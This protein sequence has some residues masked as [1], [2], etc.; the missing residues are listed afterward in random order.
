MITSTTTESQ[1]RAG[2]TYGSF[3]DNRPDKGGETHTYRTIKL[4]DGKEWM[5]ENFNFLMTMDKS[6]GFRNEYGDPEPQSR[7]GYGLFYTW[8]GIQAALPDG[9]RLPTVDEWKNLITQYGG[10]EQAYQALFTGGSSGLDLQML[11]WRAGKDYIYSGFG[12][13]GFF[14]SGSEGNDTHFAA[15]L[16]FE[17]STAKESI[18]YFRKDFYYTVRL[19][20]K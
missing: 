11:S 4:K 12:E 20:K 17:N 7:V 16:E 9:W 8:D 18:K 5:A 13:L 14:W 6:L 15:C 10:G 3:V 1:K 2:F 19:I